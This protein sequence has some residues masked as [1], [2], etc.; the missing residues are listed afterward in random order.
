MSTRNKSVQFRVTEEEK[1]LIEDYADKA[2]T[3]PSELARNAI[4]SGKRM[5]F[6]ERGK[7]I[8]TGVSQLHIAISNAVK[9]NRADTLNQAELMESLEKI[10]EALSYVMDEVNCLSDDDDDD[11]TSN[12]DE[13]VF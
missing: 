12:D 8:A 1:K 7:E 11:L 4:L 6:L 13:E 3:S 9:C 10:W 5:V 2:G